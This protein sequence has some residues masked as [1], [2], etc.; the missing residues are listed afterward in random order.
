M[1]S[2]AQQV[3]VS[4]RWSCFLNEEEL[5]ADEEDFREVCDEEK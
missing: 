1:E 2:P 3:R 4:E 5:P